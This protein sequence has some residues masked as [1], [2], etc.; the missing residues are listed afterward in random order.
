MLGDMDYTTTDL[1]PTA[2]VIIDVQNDFVDCVIPVPST[3]EII[4]ELGRVLNAFRK[5]RQVYRA[6]HPVLRTRTLRRRPHPT[7]CHRARR[8]DRRTKRARSLDPYDHHRPARHARRRP[9][10][11]RSSAGDRPHRGAALQAPL[12]RLP[13]HRAGE[14][15]VRSRPSWTRAAT[16]RAAVEPPSSTPR[17]DGLPAAAGPAQL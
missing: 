3:A 1:G 4:P 13:P 2:L 9:P 15:A 12:E 6:R 10:S 14:L 7:R 8:P 5:G 17:A 11:G 16:C